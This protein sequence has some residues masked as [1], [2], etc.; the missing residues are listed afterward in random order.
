M[1]RSAK[2]PFSFCR[3]FGFTL[4]ELLVVIAIIGM[5]IAL[6]LPAVQAAREAARRAQCTNNLKQIGLAVHNFHD[7][8]SAL[9]PICIFASRPPIHIL[10][11]PY[12]EAQA[13]YEQCIT[14]GLFNKCQTASGDDSSVILTDPQGLPDAL[15]KT[16]AVSVYRCPAALNYSPGYSTGM[17]NTGAEAGA[18]PKTSYAALYAKNNLTN[19][20][21]RYYCVHRSD[22]DQRNQNTFVG[23]FKTAS[24]TMNS[25][26]NIGSEGHRKRIVNWT[27]S[28]TFEWWSD[29][30]SNQLCFAEKFIPGWAYR[31][32]GW[33]AQ[34]WDGSYADTYPN[35]GCARMARIVSDTPGLFATGINDPD[36]PDKSHKSEPTDQTVGQTNGGNE[37]LGSCHPGI[38]N[39]LVGDGSVHTLPITMR[40]LV[41]TR[42]T[43]VNDANVAALP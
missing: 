11:L 21:E 20:W 24:V 41:T 26:G 42:L 13:A 12:I 19:H 6:L 27:Y 23:P 43:A 14:A 7:T 39:A 25:G 40:P 18:G 30:A 15:K 34:Y 29:G 35:Q 36:R 3:L 38:V 1:G 22:G 28:Q 2:P 5:L 16:L 32:V 4:V 8:N 31:D 37:Q 17:S 33:P 10:L 9:P